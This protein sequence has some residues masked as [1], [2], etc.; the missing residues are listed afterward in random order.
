MKSFADIKRRLV[1]V[2][3]SGLEVAL[4][5][6]EVFWGA[7][8]VVLRAALEEMVGLAG[9]AEQGLA[10]LLVERKIQVRDLM[11]HQRQEE[12]HEDLRKHVDQQMVEAVECK[13]TFVD[14]EYEIRGRRIRAC[15]HCRMVEEAQVMAAAEARFAICRD[16]I[17]G[18][19]RDC[20]AAQMPDLDGQ[21]KH[22]VLD[23]A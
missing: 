2:E 17:Y 14:T 12:A 11:E 9:E 7:K 15:L 4:E 23:E 21:C 8:P 18:A 3:K 13:H 6:L 20:D 10:R 22:F 16:C 19:G 5:V 1:G